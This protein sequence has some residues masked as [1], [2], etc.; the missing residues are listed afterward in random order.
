MGSLH[1]IVQH[2]IVQHD[3]VQHDIVQHD[4]V[5]HDR[6]TKMWTSKDIVFSVVS[7][8]NS[9]VSTILSKCILYFVVF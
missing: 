2:D 7:S 8:A 5:Q 4:I 1:D 3:I 6:N 9:C